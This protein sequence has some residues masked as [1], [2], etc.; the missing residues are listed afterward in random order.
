MSYPHNLI[1]PA[2][3]QKAIIIVYCVKI[4]SQFRQIVKTK[5]QEIKQKIVATLVVV[6]MLVMI[7]GVVKVENI[8]AE[9]DNAILELIVSSGSLS[10]EAADQVNFATVTLNAVTVNTTANMVQVNMRDARGSGAGWTATGAANYLTAA[11]SSNIS[12]IWLRWAPG[13]IYALDGADNTGVVSGA[14]YSG[15]FGDGSRTL[16]NT[17][18]NNGMGNYVINGTI[19]NLTIDSETPAA[20]Y[21]NTLTLTIS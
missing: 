7:A 6:F 9:A 11:N 21:H 1:L 18:T 4:C 16:A 2:L 17:S 12:N 10:I 15:N 3:L 19:L 20:T 14:D 13:D 5:K 8:R